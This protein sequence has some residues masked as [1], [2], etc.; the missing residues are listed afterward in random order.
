[1]AFAQT[2]MSHSR[3]DATVGERRCRD[4]AR[5]ARMTRTFRVPPARRAPIT[6]APSAQEDAPAIGTGDPPAQG[7]RVYARSSV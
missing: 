1:M 6:G 4:L 5:G 2:P 3:S 7:V